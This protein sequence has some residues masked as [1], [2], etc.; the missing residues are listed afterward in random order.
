MDRRRTWFA[1]ALAMFAAWVAALG[2]MAAT[3]EP[4]PGS[5]AGAAAPRL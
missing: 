1:V 2:F 5:E 3:A 4:P